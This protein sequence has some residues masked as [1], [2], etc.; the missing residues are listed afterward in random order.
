MIR[1][2]LNMKMA[3]MIDYDIPVDIIKSA[4]EIYNTIEGVD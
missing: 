2:S 1:I 3:E 4:D